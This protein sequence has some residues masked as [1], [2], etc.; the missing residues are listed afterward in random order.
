MFRVLLQPCIG[1]YLFCFMHVATAISIQQ[2][3]RES[4]LKMNVNGQ[5]FYKSGLKVDEEQMKPLNELE[6]TLKNI[7]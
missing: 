3:N 4:F 5:K 2:N 1:M 6:N 7:R